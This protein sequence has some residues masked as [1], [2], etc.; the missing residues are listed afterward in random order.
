MKKPQNMSDVKLEFNI[1]YSPLTLF[2]QTKGEEYKLGICCATKLIYVCELNK[3][4]ES[5]QIH[6]PVFNN[7]SSSLLFIYPILLFYHLNSEIDHR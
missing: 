1:S 5:Q 2:S 3:K 4:E 6:K 7:Y